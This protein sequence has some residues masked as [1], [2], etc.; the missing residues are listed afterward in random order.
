MKRCTG[1]VL[2]VLAV[3]LPGARHAAAEPLATD[4]NIVTALDIS[5][6]ISLDDI[7]LELQGMAQA[8]QDPRVH[9]A[10]QAGAN[11]RIGFA[12]FAWHRNRF[13]VAVPWMVIALPEDA[14]R[15]ARAI[16]A[17]MLVNV[18]YE[19]RE[20]EQW[21]IGRLTDLSQ[22]I[23]HAS[24]MLLLAPFASARSVINV[25]GNGE[26]NVGEEAGAARDRFVARG[27]TI[28]GL[29][30]GEDSAMA[31]YYGQHVIGGR[32]AFVMATA[33]APSIADA[34][35]RKFLGDIVAGAAHDPDAP[36]GAQGPAISGAL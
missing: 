8:I 21:Y 25:V 34:F 28:N 30:L 13:P 9:R 35:V 36:S 10:I 17:R 5:D 15:A 16:E 14:R 7:R 32:G 19:S 2:V 6:S 26:D 27:G 4:V 23:D 31:E 12:V 3:A 18:A 33:D 29:V 24:E 11:R 22:A 1:A 20:H